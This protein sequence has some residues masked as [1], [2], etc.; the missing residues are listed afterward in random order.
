MIAT[1]VALMLAMPNQQ[2]GSTPGAGGVP[3]PAYELLLTIASG[4]SASPS[5]GMDFGGGTYVYCLFADGSWRDTAPGRGLSGYD[6]ASERRQHPADFGTWQRTSGVLTLR[7]PFRQETL[8]PQADGSLLR[9]DKEARET[10]YF[11]IPSST[12]LRFAGRYSREGAAQGQPAIFITFR[13]DGTFEDHGVV[14]QLAPDEVGVRYRDISEVLGPGSG[15]YDVADNTMTLSYAD[16]RRKKTLFVLT[17]R[18]A[19]SKEPDA[20]YLGKVWFKK[21]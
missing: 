18:L 11:R 6:L 1:L 21:G 3:P 19:S 14:R 13:A 10:T 15:S 2:A 8:Y 7:T 16:G 5:G 4:L 20:I 12:G 9:K 17:P